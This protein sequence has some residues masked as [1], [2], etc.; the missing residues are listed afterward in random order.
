MS[1]TNFPGTNFAHQVSAGQADFGER[2]GKQEHKG[3]GGEPRRAGEVSGHKG[4]HYAG[5]KMEQNSGRV[6]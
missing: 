3:M 2:D 5:Q 6:R 4:L 1:N